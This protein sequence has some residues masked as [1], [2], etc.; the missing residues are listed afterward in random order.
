MTS[1]APAQTSIELESEMAQRGRAG[2]VRP[3]SESDVPRLL[4]LYRRLEPGR[5]HLSSQLLNRILFEQPWADES[6]PSLAYEDDQGEI[7]G[8]LG[9]MPRRMK[10]RG[11]NIRAAV[12]HHFVIDPSRKGTRAGVELARQFLRGPQ[13]LSLAEGSESSR[14][15]WEFLGGSASLLHSLCWARPLRP[16]Q[17]ALC[18]L[19]QSGLPSASSFPIAAIGQAM[20]A[21]LQVLP[22]NTYRIRRPAVLSD[23]LDTVT[24][25]AFLSAFFNRHSLEPVYDLASLT[26]MIELLEQKRHRGTLHKVA[27]RAPSG[28][29]LGW[30]L[31]YLG[32]DGIA[33]V[34]QLGGSPE[35]I[36]EVVNHLFH[37]AWQR[38]AIAATGLMESRYCDVLARNHCTFHRPDKWMLIHAW[39]QQIVNRVNAGDAFL[40]RLEG[41]W[42]ISS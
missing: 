36:S 25:L 4:D 10:F 5:S 7:L 3:L 16:A 30:Y 22:R 28:R 42:W 24:L 40:S 15:I 18:R 29:P 27:V 8:S 33:D 1:T 13:D 2:R 23:E 41:E 31:Y 20:D 17:F 9:V 34:I 32:S 12:A 11:D 37:H 26:W 38:G 39:D 6:L 21:A 14:R 35:W 19:N